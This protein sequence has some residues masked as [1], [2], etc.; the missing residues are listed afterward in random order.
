MSYEPTEEELAPHEEAARAVQRL[1]ALMARLRAPGGCPWDREQTLESLRPYLLE[2]TYEVLEAIDRGDAAHHLEELGDLLLQI[3]FQAEIRRESG[4][5]TLAEVARGI[6][7]KLH[8]RHPHVFGDAEAADASTAF[9]NWERQKAKEKK[10]RKSVLDGVPRAA[11]ALMRA[12]RLTDKAAA[13]GFD[14]PDPMGARRKI[15]E[16]LAELDAAVAAEAQERI[17]AELG[18]LLFA[19]VNYGRK[20]GIHPE[21]ALRGTLERFEDRF[22]HIERRLAE[23]GRSPKEAGL[24]EMDALWEE[25]KG[26]GSDAR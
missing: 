21:D 5:W 20:L 4:E 8:R 26:G 16:E 10:E 6:T 11:P 13:V 9:E 7:D 3:V 25:A 24:E 19:V 15:D 22:R 17:E 14:W 12:E 23:Q 2:E 18:D 1:L